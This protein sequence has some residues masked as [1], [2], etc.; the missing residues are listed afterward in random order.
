[1]ERVVRLKASLLAG[2]RL[3]MCFNKPR[4]ATVLNST[5]TI[6]RTIM[7]IQDKYVYL[8]KAAIFSYIKKSP[9]I[10]NFVGR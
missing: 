8:I 1:V 10:N 9:H 6:T 5:L 4:T 2:E 7:S 3:K